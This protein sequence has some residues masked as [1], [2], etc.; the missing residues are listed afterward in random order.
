MTIMSIFKHSQRDTEQATSSSQLGGVAAHTMLS[1]VRILK[2]VRC[3]RLA[4]LSGELP[5]PQRCICYGELRPTALSPGQ[6]E[7]IGQGYYS[8]KEEPE[9]PYGQW[10]Q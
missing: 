4:L 3:G 9:L 10:H 2:C 7:L 5:E 1:P 8:G 6:Y